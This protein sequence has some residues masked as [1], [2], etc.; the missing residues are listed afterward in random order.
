[1]RVFALSDIHVDYE[2]NKRWLFNLSRQDYQQ[3][4]LILAG[5]ITD[6][7]AVLEQCFGYLSS[8]FHQVLYVPGN[9]ELWVKRDA[10]KCSFEK[11]N[12][13]SRLASDCDISMQYYQTDALGIVPLLAWYDFS[14]G[15]PGSAL[16]AAWADFYHC[17]WPDGYREAEITHYF[18]S[19]N[20]I[21]IDKA[22]KTIISFSHFLPS[23]DVMPSYIPQK[24]RYLYPVLGSQALGRQVTAL[25]PAIHVY[26]HS[27][28]N[29]QVTI[30]GIQYINN[31]FGYPSEE[32][33]K[34]QLLCIYQT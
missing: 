11:F 17:R 1:M 27:H 13:I 20:T 28:V 18:L 9:H 8:I 3:D 26:G 2:G 6:D 5:D 21:D 19:K 24:H 14:F 16:N 34:K 25:N 33:P 22:D 32:W 31:A 4:I 7:L 15:V 10:I 12:T 23:I 29:R 30:N